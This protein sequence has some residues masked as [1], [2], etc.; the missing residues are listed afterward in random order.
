MFSAS[1]NGD[2]NQIKYHITNSEHADLLNI[3]YIYIAS[4][5]LHEMSSEGKEKHSQLL[6]FEMLVL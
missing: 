3:Q 6:W 5:A 2:P 4:H 1:A